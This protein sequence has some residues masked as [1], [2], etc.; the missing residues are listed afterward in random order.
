M[1]SLSLLALASA[2]LAADRVPLEEVDPTLIKPKAVVVRSESLPAIREAPIPAARN[3][4]HAYHD[5]AKQSLSGAEV[6]VD[7]RSGRLGEASYSL[8]AYRSQPTG[9]DYQLSACVVRGAQAW[10]LELSID[11]ARFDAGLLMLLQRI[12][13]LGG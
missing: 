2:L 8:L 10:R 6:V 4:P 5:Q 13:Q 3:L 7:R 12:R 11:E 1:R 9:R